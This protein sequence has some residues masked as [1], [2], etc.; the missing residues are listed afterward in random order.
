[1]DIHAVTGFFMRRFR[2]GRMQRIKEMFPLLDSG[3]SVL[4]V[5]GTWGWWKMMTVKT[6]DITIVN[7]DTYHEKAVLEA[8]YKFSSANGCAMPYADRQFD[9]T[10]SNSVIE[11]VGGLPEQRRFAAEVL[12]CGKQVYLQTPNKWF[13]VEPHMIALFIHWLPFSVQRHLVRW[14]SVWG[15]V[16]KPNQ[17]EVDEFLKGIRLMSGK[18]VVELFPGCDI[19]KEKVL[20]LVKSFI[21]VRR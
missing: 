4:D 8:G 10:F 16:T 11:H 3:G 19:Q 9:L 12:R 5:G 17:A 7:L 18:E 2:P 1:M 6:R 21:V 13:P 15:W 14:L 20:G